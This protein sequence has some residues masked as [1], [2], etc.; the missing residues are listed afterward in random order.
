MYNINLVRPGRLKGAMNEVVKWKWQWLKWKINT[1][2][3]GVLDVREHSF[4]K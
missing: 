4:E 3:G 2:P 1:K